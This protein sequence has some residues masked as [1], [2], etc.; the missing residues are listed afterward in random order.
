[1]QKPWT[2]SWLAA[3]C[4]ADQS[5]S[6]CVVSRS[7]DEAHSCNVYVSLLAVRTRRCVCVCVS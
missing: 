2:P 4:R 5:R 7:F 3:V 6:G 1:M